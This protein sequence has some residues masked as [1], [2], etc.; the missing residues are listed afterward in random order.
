MQ[1]LILHTQNINDISLIIQLAERLGI[2]YTQKK[3]VKQVRKKE[4][5]EVI[6]TLTKPMGKTL[7]IEALKK[8][9]NYKG[10]NRKRFDK[11]IKEMDI[12][13]TAEELI[14]QL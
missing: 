2:P 7:D 11:L 12:P 6:L 13:Q 5:S 1:T 3:E 14:A 8:E 4:V 10:V 9:R